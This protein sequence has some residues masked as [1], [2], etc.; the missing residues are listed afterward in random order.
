M[1]F[2]RFYLFIFLLGSLNAL[3]I[4]TTHHISQ[5][6]EL[7]DQGK[8]DSA[9][10]QGVLF[11]K[12]Y[13]ENTDLAFITGKSFFL[14]ADLETA[15]YYFNIVLEKKG[16]S[17]K[18][19]SLA[20]LGL[21]ELEIFQ[22]NLPRA[23]ELLSS[24]DSVHLSIHKPE[25]MPSLYFMYARYFFSTNDELSK[26]YYELALLNTDGSNSE[27]I[28]IYLSYIDFLLGS[29]QLLA[30]TLIDSTET[31]ITGYFKN[32]LP[33]KQ[34]L[35]VHK[36]QYLYWEQRYSE[37]LKLCKLGI[38]NNQRINVRWSNLSS[39]RIYNLKVHTLLELHDYYRARKAAENYVR[40]VKQ[41][42]MIS[43]DFL[44]FAY[45][46]LYEINYYLGNYDVAVE[47]LRKSG[48]S[49]FGFDINYYSIYSALN[50]G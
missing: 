13:P 19:F 8:Y 20:L 29:D 49:G 18:Q 15:D 43:N 48:G 38:L 27:T 10:H 47:F 22:L 14:N 2:S 33:F 50:R 39:M 42:K 4:Q 25:L 17:K 24:I 21:A 3:G 35:L 44:L 11:L 37:A 26:K 7:L 9:A 1:T 5:V 28:R 32:H 40:E 23:Y 36:I 41:L 12:Q 45:K 46:R 6:M 34:E 30:K 31:I 16:V